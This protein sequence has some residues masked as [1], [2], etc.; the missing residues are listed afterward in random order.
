MRRNGIQIRPATPD[1]V[2][3]LLRFAEQVP[4]V[5]SGRR[6]GS[7][8]PGGHDPRERYEMLVKNPERRVLLAVGDADSVVGMAVLSLDV[9]GEL[10]DVPVVRVSHLVVDR[11]HRKRG[12]G[13]ALLASAAAYADEVGVDYVT[14]G[15]VTTDREANRF[16]ARLGFAPLIV[17]RIAPLPVLRRQLAVPDAPDLVRQGRPGRMMRRALRRTALGVAKDFV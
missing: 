2:D 5:P 15:A 13:R 6:H 17:R 16:L 14:V 7:R 11:P 9:A 10:L 12:A 4:N 1:D 8:P 3:T